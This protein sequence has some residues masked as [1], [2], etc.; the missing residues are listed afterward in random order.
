MV[1]SFSGNNKGS[2]FIEEA[3]IMENFS[4]NNGNGSS[5]FQGKI[6]E[7]DFSAE[8]KL[9]ELKAAIEAL[10]R[11]DLLRRLEC[12]RQASSCIDEISSQAE[13]H[14]GEGDVED[15]FTGEK[16]RVLGD[17][18][19]FFESLFNLFEVDVDDPKIYQM[20]KEKKEKNW[21]LSIIKFMRDKLK[22]LIKKIFARDLS[23]NQK[24]DKKIKELQEKLGSG[25]LSEEEFAR[26]LERLTALQD[27]KLRLQMA[28][29][30][31][32]VTMFAEMFGVELAAAVEAST[33]KE[34]KKAEKTSL[35]EENK[36]VCENVEIKVD[37]R[38]KP[39]VPVFLFEVSPGFVRPVVLSKP[40]LEI[41]SDPL[42]HLLRLTELERK[43]HENSQKQKVEEEKKAKPEEPKKEVCP[44]KLPDKKPVASGIKINF[45]KIKNIGFQERDAN[46]S[47][48]G[49]GTTPPTNG[50]GNKLDNGKKNE[51]ASY[52]ASRL[53]GNVNKKEA[54]NLYTELAKEL[55]NF[56][57]GVWNGAENEGSVNDAQSPRGLTNDVKV[58]KCVEGQSVGKT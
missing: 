26:A 46:T 23:F 42:K 10:T 35:K 47:V 13:L 3:K 22:E 53:N 20:L 40:E 14:I 51:S 38:E 7:Q 27:L 19:N 16:G 44:P 52:A 17:F 45:N 49:R 9:N 54:D 1:E 43:S 8:Q 56:K 29:V 31:W 5:I 48:N 36:E 28:V 37:E 11:Q 6:R 25:E 12:E 4:D 18:W 57:I 15:Y 24:L 50:Q 39:K 30:G 41:A 21:L 32:I 55:A 34:D 33:E 2:N 58:E